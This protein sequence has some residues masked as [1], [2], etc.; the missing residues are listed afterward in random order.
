[1]ALGLM[2]NSGIK[3]SQAGTTLKTALANLSAPTKAQAGEMER[4]G[5]SMTNADG[6]M[7]SLA[8]LTDSLRSSFSELSE[9]EQ[10]AAARRLCPGC[11]RSSTP[12]RR[13]WT[14]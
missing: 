2:A 12:D 9:A 14:A 7:K 10:T 8:Q 3:S 6:T 4:L 1:M 13:T 11:W 5:I